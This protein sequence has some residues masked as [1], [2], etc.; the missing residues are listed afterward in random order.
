APAAGADRE[1]LSWEDLYAALSPQQQQ[2]LL[3]LA[4]RQGLLQAH[5]LPAVDPAPMQQRRQLLTQLLSGKAHNL[6]E[7]SP[8]PLIVRDEALDAAQREAVARA[9]HTPDVCLIQGLPGS[10]KSRL[11]AE[12][13]RQTSARGERVLL[14]GATPAPPGTPGGG[15]FAALALDCS[16][17]HDAQNHKLTA[18]KAQLQSSLDSLERDRSAARAK[19]E[20]TRPL[21]E[22]WRAKRWWTPAWWKALFNKAV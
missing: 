13:L 7:F 17:Q 4:A 21:A 3:D 8:A 9:V 14:L 12:I 11:A 15:A 2:E 5:Q 1:S 18:E 20:A 10:G 19:R 22:A 16:Q 6:G